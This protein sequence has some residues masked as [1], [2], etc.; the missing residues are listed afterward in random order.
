MDTNFYTDSCTHSVDPYVNPWWAVDLGEMRH[1]H[2][3]SITNRN[4]LGR[5]FYINTNESCLI[6]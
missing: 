6:Y 3:V 5:S 1:V 4:E 2:A